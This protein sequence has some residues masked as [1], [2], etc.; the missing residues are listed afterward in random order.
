MQDK[1]EEDTEKVLPNEVVQQCE[2]LPFKDIDSFL[3]DNIRFNNLAEVVEH[4]VAPTLE[5]RFLD[6]ISDA[7]QS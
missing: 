2:L 5:V 6:V 4:I 1:K 7:E 3:R